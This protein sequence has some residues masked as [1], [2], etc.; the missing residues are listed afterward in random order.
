MDQQAEDPLPTDDE[1]MRSVKALFKE[2]NGRSVKRLLARHRSDCLFMPPLLWDHRL[3][4]LLQCRFLPRR[5]PT[6]P[7]PS[8][9]PVPDEDWEPMCP[10]DEETQAENLHYFAEPHTA[11][12][13]LDGR[14]PG[15]IGG[16]HGYA[17]PCWAFPLFER[18]ASVL[19]LL[20]LS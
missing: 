4:A 7:L 15:N 11:F 17:C 20:F 14:Y 18:R 13:L 10:E 6:P 19:I 1:F 16:C 2:A 3:P 8:A 5:S 9:P 12:G